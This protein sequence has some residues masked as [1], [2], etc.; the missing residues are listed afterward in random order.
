MA[1]PPEARVKHSLSLLAALSMLAVANL[2]RAANTDGA[3]GL[4]YGDG[5]SYQV[6]APAGWVLDTE[7]GVAD[8]LSAVFYP[9]GRTWTNAEAVMYVHS[10][11][12]PAGAT[13]EQVIAGEAASFM[14]ASGGHPAVRAVGA[15]ALE[16]GIHAPVRLFSGDRYGNHEAIAYV[17]TPTVIGLVVLSAH[18]QPAFDAALPAFRALVRSWQYAGSGGPEVFDA[19]LARA[20]QNEATPEGGRYVG[21]KG[22]IAAARSGLTS[23]MQ[24][25]MGADSTDVSAFDLVAR[26]AA[27]GSVVDTEVRPGTDL[28]RCF[29]AEV[30]RLKLSPPPEPEWWIHLHMAVNP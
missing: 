29:A 21:P 5:F 24:Q 12:R 10:M 3:T 18:Q 30:K 13:L 11:E 1:P 15:V 9:A 8:G 26:V 7:A 14:H 2:A 20:K 25:C 6:T 17:E 19:A 28:A 4:V 27:D 22:A 16:S 23:A